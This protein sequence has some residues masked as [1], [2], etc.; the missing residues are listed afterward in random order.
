[1]ANKKKQKRRL[2]RAIARRYKE[3]D[4]ARTD[5]ALRNIFVRNGVLKDK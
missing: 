4:R 1:M 2:G 3:V 5:R